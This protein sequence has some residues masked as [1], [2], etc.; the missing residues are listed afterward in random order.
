MYAQLIILGS[1]TALFL[2]PVAVL[3]MDS[4]KTVCEALSFD[5][6]TVECPIINNQNPIQY[7]NANCE[8]EIGSSICC[9][10]GSDKADFYCTPIL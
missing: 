7:C 1:L 2:N 5:C 6:S 3:A 8:P 4:T 10:V 9:D